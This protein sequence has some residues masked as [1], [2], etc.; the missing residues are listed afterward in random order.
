MSSLKN[1]VSL[2]WGPRKF[3]KETFTVGILLARFGPIFVKYLQ[4]PFAISKGSEIILLPDLK[5][6][7]RECILLFLLMTSLIKPPS[8]L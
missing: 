7:S 6:D 1:I 8:L 2:T 4:N 5:E 3:W